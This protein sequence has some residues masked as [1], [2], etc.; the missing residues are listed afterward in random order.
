MREI[1]GLAD[2]T[3]LSR[4]QKALLLYV[5][6]PGCGVCEADRPRAEALAERLGFPLY[7]LN[8]AD[9]PEAAGQLSLFTAPAVLLFLEGREIHRQARFID[10]AELE[11]RM[12]Q[13]AD[14]LA[15][16]AGGR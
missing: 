12:R 15:E 1:K 7:T 4:G 2:F 5:S 16:E 8:I 6:A 11:Y 9:V 13:A 14:Y 3:A 10:F